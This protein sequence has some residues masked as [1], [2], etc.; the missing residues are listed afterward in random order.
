MT[1]SIVARDPANGHFG[2]A[3]ASRFFSVGTLVPNIRPGVGAVATQAF[4]NPLYG[5]DGL[6]LLQEG[7][8][9]VE[10]VAT[11]TAA[12][13]GRAHR[14]LHVIDRDGRI[15]LTLRIHPG[16]LSRFESRFAANIKLEQGVET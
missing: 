16:D 5:I 9:A 7:R 11:L 12:D 4:V 15:A 14:Q 2:I 6:R 1:W 8:S 10:I 13:E 3:V